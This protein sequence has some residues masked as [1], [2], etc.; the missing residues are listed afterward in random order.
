MTDK[1]DILKLAVD[2]LK[3]EPFPHRPPKSVIDKTIGRLKQRT[4]DNGGKTAAADSLFNSERLKM[5]FR[6]AAAAAVIIAV[7]WAVNMFVGRAEK[8]TQP[9]AGKGAGGEKVVEPADEDLQEKDWTK[10]A[11][12]EV[13]PALTPQNI[14]TMLAKGEIDKLAASLMDA[15]SQTQVAAVKYLAKIDSPAAIQALRT[16]SSRLA[17]DQPDNPFTRAFADINSV[18][19][20]ANQAEPN[21]D[22]AA[23]PAGGETGDGFYVKVVSKATGLPIEGARVPVKFDNK[24]TNDRKK[25]KYETDA[26]GKVW[27][28]VLLPD[29][30]S[31]TVIAAQNGFVKM[32]YWRYRTKDVVKKLPEELIFELPPATSL[33]GYVKNESGRPV[34]GAKVY[35]GAYAKTGIKH[36]SYPN[37]RKHFDVT[38][39]NGYWEAKDFPAEIKS[40]SVRL[41][42]PDYID[43]RTR[44]Q[45]F[46]EELQSLTS[47]IVAKKGIVLEGLVTAPDG[48]SVEGADLL[49]GES[50]YSDAPQVKT[51]AHGRFSFGQRQAGRQYI[52]V[53][54]KGFAPEVERINVEPNMPPVAIQLKEP[55]TI[56]GQVVDIN[57]D[58]IAGVS[59]SADSWKGIRTIRWRQQTNEDGRFEWNEAPD[60]EVL[61][62]FY[63]KGYMSTREVAMSPAID[64]YVIVMS[65]PL[66]VTGTVCDAETGEPIDK[67]KITPGFLWREGQNISWQRN[68]HDQREFT[69]GRYEY[70]FT[71]G[72]LS[73]ALK[74]EAPGHNPAVSDTFVDDGNEVVLN[75]RLEP[76]D[77]P[78]GTVYAP[79][80]VPLE[81][82][83]VVVA[84]R[85]GYVQIRDGN[86]E[87][88][89]RSVF[90]VTDSSGGFS[91]PPQID[92][93][94][95]IALH[96]QGL[97]EVT[98]EQFEQD[99]NIVIA[100]WGK[101]KGRLFTGSGPGGNEKIALNYNRPYQADSP[102]INYRYDTI[103][104]A[105]GDFSF[106]KVKP[107][108]AQ[109]SQS[110]MIG[111]HR[112]TYIRRQ[113]VNIVP[114]GTA[115]VQLGGTGRPVVG[116]LTVPPDYKK[117]VDFSLGHASL[118][119]KLPQQE[120][121]FSAIRPPNAQYMTRKEWLNWWESYTQSPDANELVKEFLQL[122]PVPQDYNRMSEAEI[123]KWFS[124]WAKSEEGKAAREKMQE[125]MKRH[126]GR[127]QESRYYS[128][129]VK[130]D[131]SFRA[132][133]VPAGKY[134]FSC[135]VYEAKGEGPYP[136]NRGERI[137]TLKKE[138]EIAEIEGSRS[139]EP[140]DL[141]TLELESVVQTTTGDTAQNFDVLT[142][143]GREVSLADY[144]GK[145]LVLCFEHSLMSSRKDTQQQ[146]KQV[147]DSFSDDERF[148][149]LTIWI[150]AVPSE[151]QSTVE[152]KQLGWD[153]A[154]PPLEQ[155][156]ELA[157]KYSIGRYPAIFVI[158]GDGSV[159][160]KSYETKDLTEQ[161]EKALSK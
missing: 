84:T 98:Q 144:A 124:E 33:G 4:A 88:S 96:K 45:P 139:D 129:I 66:S 89:D 161:I 133:D 18:E 100:P 99:A 34:E 32:K 153:H 59:L 152:E 113:D 10:V 67:F 122:Y 130:P 64:E 44:P 60:D 97:A 14:K 56:S 31:V 48:K 155:R 120:S 82:A 78:A 65:S 142:V 114:S 24:E 61:F 135:Y 116:K 112:S 41:E 121:L 3:S 12:A 118:R 9:I 147:Y 63:K 37:L 101:L 42:H 134:E 72:H 71:E 49:L 105:N 13:E 22:Q 52:T 90:T 128:V 53:Q 92:K 109:V 40:A 103:T 157:E 138:F 108:R 62:D 160:H 141:G 146:L 125:L 95:L 151:V 115:V 150:A 137:G 158:D 87:N 51:D 86:L 83:T 106:D 26:R 93:Y 16:I 54:A 73:Y 131:G 28:P 149:M 50:R 123:V 19:Q 80:G 154:A 36:M 148:A 43:M 15:D 143:D 39:A 75:F 30:D 126:S 46:I 76:A 21:D 11:T 57:E 68:T 1:M 29:A 119:A 6:I 35:P 145:V 107:G 8:A 140:F 47:V 27:V 132:E 69:S 102:R 74:I 127:T 23:L 7:L 156:A 117:Q 70:E 5:Y 85:S 79:D 20:D 91:I 38:D 58:P 77:N 104:D 159:I 110:V 136:R 17:A 55:Q 94:S 111:P 25:E 2:A 81:T